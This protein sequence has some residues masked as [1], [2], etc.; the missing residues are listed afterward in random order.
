MK[1]IAEVGSAF[2]HCRVNYPWLYPRST[3]EQTPGKRLSGASG[4][5]AAQPIPKASPVATRVSVG[6][7][8]PCL[9]F[10][11][12]AYLSFLTVLI[13]VAIILIYGGI[14]D[15]DLM[16]YTHHSSLDRVVPYMLSLG[17]MV[18]DFAL[19]DV[20]AILKNEFHMTFGIRGKRILMRTSQPMNTMKKILVCKFEG[21]CKE[22]IKGIFRLV[23]FALISV[24]F[25]EVSSRQTKELIELM[26]PFAPHAEVLSA[27]Q[28]FN[29]K[30]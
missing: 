7:F 23:F 30:N 5:D 21:M 18:V 13:M 25:R 16:G 1:V 14:H 20:Y 29:N 17:I 4:G 19:C 28:Q 24:R 8:P 3:M 6:T 11:F 22:T 27:K 12:L 9:G 15:V 26:S 2:L 10:A